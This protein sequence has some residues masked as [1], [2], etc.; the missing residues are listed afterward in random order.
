[1]FHLYML[2]LNLLRSVLIWIDGWTLVKNLDIFHFR[3]SSFQREVSNADDSLYQNT[4][5]LNNEWKG[6]NSGGI[7]AGF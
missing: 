6:F 3:E 7:T 2:L 1:M 4:P 5:I